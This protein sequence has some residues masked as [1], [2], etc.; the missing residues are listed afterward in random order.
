M[1]TLFMWRR[2]ALFYVG[3]WITF[4]YMQ[5]SADF[6]SCM[7]RCYATSGCVAWYFIPM[8]CLKPAEKKYRILY[9]NTILFFEGERSLFGTH[10]HVYALHH[11]LFLDEGNMIQRE[12]LFSWKI[13][14]QLYLDLRH[15][16]CKIMTFNWGIEI[17]RPLKSIWFVV[18]SF[19]FHFICLFRVY[20]I[21]IVN[22]KVFRASNRVE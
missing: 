11:I 8:S 15:T 6:S 3:P 9:R 7:M 21:Q 16:M 17:W 10:L 12:F 13:S 4:F 18:A 2:W 22:D 5:S 14:F 1:L 19:S 20:T